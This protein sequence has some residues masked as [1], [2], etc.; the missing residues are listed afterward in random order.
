M[1]LHE[2]LDMVKFDK[3]LVDWNLK[4]GIISQADY[5]KHMKSL[6]DL[7]AHSEVVTLEGE[8]DEDDADISAPQ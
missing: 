7:V 5:E 1:D 3:R 2:A 8:G 4:Q 6:Q